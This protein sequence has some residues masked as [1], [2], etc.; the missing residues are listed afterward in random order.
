MEKKS[1]YQLIRANK[2]GQ[3]I[4]IVG[5]SGSGKS[6]HAREIIAKQSGVH[7]LILDLKDDAQDMAKHLFSM[8]QR[9]AITND[10]I[11]AINLLQNFNVVIFTPSENFDDDDISDFLLRFYRNVRNAGICFDEAYLLKATI[12]LK[13]LLTRGRSRNLSVIS[14]SQRPV[15][16]PSVCRSESNHVFVHRLKLPKDIQTIQE[17]TGADKAAIS[18]LAQ[19]DYLYFAD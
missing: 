17:L 18:N 12:G 5:A 10:E 8:G 15:V 13:T 2:D 19:Y 14:C 3:R 6:H 11:K 9:V 16:V 1:S 4:L 7:F